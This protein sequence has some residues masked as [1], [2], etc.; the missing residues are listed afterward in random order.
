MMTMMTQLLKSERLMV[1]HIDRVF[2]QHFRE[3]Y[4]QAQNEA[5]SDEIKLVLGRRGE[6]LVYIF[7]LFNFTLFMLQPNLVTFTVLQFVKV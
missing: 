3:Y 2:P 5:G 1:L 7:C 6:L 4:F